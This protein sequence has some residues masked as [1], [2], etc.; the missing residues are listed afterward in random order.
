MNTLSLNKYY[1]KTI[2]FS[3]IGSLLMIV[4]SK[5]VIPI[6]LIKV[7]LA[8]M[9]P[10]L[11]GF[12]A[13]SKVGFLSVTLFLVE[14]ALGVPVF[15]SS[16][17][18]GV[19]IA[20]MMGPTLGYLLSWPLAAYLTGIAKE[21]ALF[22]RGLMQNVLLVVT[23]YHIQYMGGLSWLAVLGLTNVFFIGYMPFFNNTLAQCILLISLFSYQKNR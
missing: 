14:G 19:G 20:Y 18:R 15:Q 2:F 13:G 12:Y 23:L 3:L 4:A 7:S 8:P 17:E 11:L 10:M 21:K 22:K 5:C 6:G 1:S 9:M 16:P